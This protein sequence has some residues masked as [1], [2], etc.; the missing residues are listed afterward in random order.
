[1]LKLPR[2]RELTFDQRE[3]VDA[4]RKLKVSYH[5]LSQEK[6][7]EVNRLA[8]SMSLD[9]PGCGLTFDNAHYLESISKLKK[10]Y[11]ML[12]TDVTDRISILG[13]SI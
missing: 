11:Y 6:I 10:G 2:Y 7:N 8:P 13:K 1:M 12:P 4:L 5:I 9:K 3:Y